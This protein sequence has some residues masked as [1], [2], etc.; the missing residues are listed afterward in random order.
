VNGHTSTV[1]TP[2]TEWS[3]GCPQGYR[4]PTSKEKCSIIVHIKEKGFFPK[5]LPHLPE[6]CIFVVDNAVYR[7]DRFTGFSSTKK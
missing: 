6:N 7:N 1:P 2:K 3:N 4:V 5:P